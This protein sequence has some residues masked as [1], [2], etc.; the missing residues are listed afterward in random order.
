VK[1]A[2]EQQAA[3]MTLVENLQRQDLHCLEQAEA[4]ANLSQE[5]HLTQEEIGKRVGAA[6]NGCDHSAAAG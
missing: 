2:S 1:R 6:T 5:F 4:F 3:E